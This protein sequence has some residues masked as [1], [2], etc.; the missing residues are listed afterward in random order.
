[1]RTN[2]SCTLLACCVAVSAHIVSLIVAMGVCA[3]KL[4]RQERQLARAAEFV[5]FASQGDMKN[6]LLMLKKRRVDVDA[7]DVRS[8]VR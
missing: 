4:S 8:F 7:K 1:M 5:R 3:S 2:I 6:L